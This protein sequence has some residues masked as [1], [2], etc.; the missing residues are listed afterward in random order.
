MPVGTTV[1]QHALPFSSLTVDPDKEAK[2]HQQYMTD[3]VLR[4]P[5][6]LL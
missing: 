5:L 1:S 3:S 2:I 6:F 4:H